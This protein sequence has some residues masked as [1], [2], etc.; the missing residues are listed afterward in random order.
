MISFF[1]VVCAF[2]LMFL[3]DALK[4]RKHDAAGKH[5][6][7]GG[8]LMLI[9]SGVFAAFNGT[10]FYLAPVMRAISLLVAAL[11]AWGMYVSLF[12]SLPTY[13]T[14]FGKEETI[15]LVD[16]GMYAM[17]RHPGA[18]WF[19]VF[20]G[21]LALGL[22]NLELLV[23]AALASALNVLYVWFQ[24]S[25]VFPETIKGY[26]QYQKTTP[27]ILPT[28]QSLSRAVGKKT[29]EQAKK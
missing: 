4:L 3:S 5:L 29:K 24:D 16:S 19:P 14:Y 21:F 17:C 26:N 18:L 7:G 20:S 22:G 8:A 27:F 10:R 12:S 11:G 9:A 28:A 13:R 15:D 1:L 23:D 25:R 2:A 6:F